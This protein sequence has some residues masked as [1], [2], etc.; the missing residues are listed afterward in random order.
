MK[1]VLIVL[2]CTVFFGCGSNPEISLANEEAEK[3]AWLIGEWQRTNEKPEKETFEYWTKI[4]DTEFRGFGF[5]LQDKDTVWQ[6]NITLVQSKEGWNFEVVG[7]GDTKPTIFKVT[8]LT[9]D[10]FICEN[11][12][13]DF[14]KKI[15]YTHIDNTIKASISGGD[16][17]IPFDFKRV[18]SDE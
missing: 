15:Q 5:T 9:K 3:L 17:E 1:Y 7:K 10:G 4:S 6:E 13:H 11:P 12:K 8:Q 18:E 2:A 16:M 14:P